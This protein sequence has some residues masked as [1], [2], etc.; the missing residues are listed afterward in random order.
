MVGVP[1]V[2]AISIQFSFVCFFFSFSILCVSLDVRDILK[3]HI[4]AN[5]FFGARHGLSTLQQLI[6]YDDE[7]ESL[8]ILS[9]AHIQDEP[10]FKYVNR[11]L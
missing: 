5:S 6:W 1:D 2:D 7:D 9:A 8:R 10:K 3:V 11:T 4:K